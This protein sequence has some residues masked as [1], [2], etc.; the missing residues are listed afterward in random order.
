MMWTA[1]K[2][3]IGQGY[4]TLC[5]LSYSLMSWGFPGGSVL[6]IW[7]PMQETLEMWIQFLG[8][9]DALGEQ[10]ATYS[11]ILAWRISWTEQPG[12]L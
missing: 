4:L 12:G 7:L 9:K 11:S 1:A 10:M 2:T 5:F 8:W 6:R 3:P